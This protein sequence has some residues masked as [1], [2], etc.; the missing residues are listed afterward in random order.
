MLQF[1]ALS[2][3]K[4]TDMHCR[5]TDTLFVVSIAHQ[6]EANG[7]TL[8]VTHLKKSIEGGQDNSHGEI[9]RINKVECLCHSNEDLIIHTRW[10]TLHIQT[11]V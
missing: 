9:I 10:H 8:T 5:S 7:K 6:K 1:V 2:T 11:N 3:M 4:D